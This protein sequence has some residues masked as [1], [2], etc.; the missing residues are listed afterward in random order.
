MAQTSVCFVDE[1]QKIVVNKDFVDDLHP[2]DEDWTKPYEPFLQ[3]ALSESLS[4]ALMQYRGWGE[5]F[6]NNFEVIEISKNGQS[7]MTL[8]DSETWG[9]LPAR[10]GLETTD[11]YFIR[12]HP[13]ITSD[14]LFFVGKSFNSQPPLLTGVLITDDD[15][16]LVFNKSCKVMEISLDPF[17]IILEDRLPEYVLDEAGNMCQRTFPKFF[18]LFL[19]DG[20]LKFVEKK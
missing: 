2:Y 6:P 14:L 13:D 17:S 16:A 10:L 19:D 3:L 1:N 15:A 18:R 12:I 9:R 8:A 7:V 5:E 4:V 11:N 20:V